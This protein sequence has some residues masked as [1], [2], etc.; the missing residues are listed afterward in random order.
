MNRFFFF[1]LTCMLCFSP[2][3]SN[4]KK[5]L[6]I[7]NAFYGVHADKLDYKNAKLA[8]KLW[9]Q[10]FSKEAGVTSD[11]VFYTDFNLLKKDT[12]E[13]K[14]DALILSSYSFV[15]HAKFCKK[16]FSSGWIKKEKD[17]KPFFRYLLIARKNQK[18]KRVLTAHYYLYYKMADIVAKKYALDHK[19][20]ITT[21]SVKKKSKAILDLFFKKCDLAVTTQSSWNLM[22]ELNPQ[23]ENNLFVLYKSDRIFV[24]LIS[25]FSNRLQPNIVEIYRK[26][27]LSFGT[28]KT[29]DELMKLF[30]FNGLTI[31]DDKQLTRMVD[32]YSNY[33]KEK[34]RDAE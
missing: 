17:G 10:K 20:D 27:I 25:L 19:L 7:T 3:V 22:K 29:G 2:S 31:F 33:I 23:I 13:D 14:I 30:K 15:K 12:K 9:L 28:T 11:A 26:A 4:A 32:F 24:D 18:S 8:M 34:K 21:K 16:N 6:S 1:L 5:M